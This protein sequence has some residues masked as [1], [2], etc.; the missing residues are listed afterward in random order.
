MLSLLVQY[1]V[2][3][4]GAII[5]GIGLLVAVP[6]T[7]LIQVYTYRKLS[8]GQVVELDQAGFQ[9]GPPQG[10]PPSPYGGPAY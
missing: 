6:L 1:A 5:C 2:V 9:Q 10:L 7:L 8:G 4:V 3:L